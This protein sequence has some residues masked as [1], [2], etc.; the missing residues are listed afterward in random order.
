MGAHLGEAVGGECCQTGM[1]RRHPKKFAQAN[2]VWV[3]GP[4]ANKPHGHRRH[5]LDASP[6]LR[7]P[8]GY[9][10]RYHVMHLLCGM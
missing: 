9:I 2:V 7:D 3:P 4:P 5:S 8:E 6:L 10:M 1:V